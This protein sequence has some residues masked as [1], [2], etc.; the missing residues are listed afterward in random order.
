MML[1]KQLYDVPPAIEPGPALEEALAGLEGKVEI[2]PGMKIAV[3]VGSRGIDRLAEVVRGVVA[4]LKAWGADPFVIPAMG[5]HGGATAEG[6]ID[7]LAHR[8]VTEA[9][10][11]CPIKATMEVVPMGEA[12]LGFPLNLDRLAAEADGIVL[13]NRAKP[14]TNF[15]GRT[16][17]GVLWFNT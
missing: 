16:E 7:V 4:K 2:K 12:S 15:I 1:I 9:T 3:G 13:I 5:S 6:Q 11:G 17:S 14:H 8:G 10:V